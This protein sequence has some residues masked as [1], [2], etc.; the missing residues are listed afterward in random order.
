MNLPAVNLR[1]LVGTAPHN[2]WGCVQRA[3]TERAEQIGLVEDIWQTEI[4]N[5]SS[6]IFVK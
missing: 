3:T 5:F 4:S 2:F 1:S 6:A